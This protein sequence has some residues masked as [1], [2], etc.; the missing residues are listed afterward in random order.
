MRIATA[1]RFAIYY[2]FEGS[3]KPIAWRYWAEFET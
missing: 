3:P 2:F 1:L